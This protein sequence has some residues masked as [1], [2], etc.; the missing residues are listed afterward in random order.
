MTSVDLNIKARRMCVRVKDAKCRSAAR[1]FWSGRFG[2]VPSGP[3]MVTALLSQ[4]T[5]VQLSNSRF[6]LIDGDFTLVGLT[7]YW[8]QAF[9]TSV[10]IPAGIVTHLQAILRIGTFTTDRIV[11]V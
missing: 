8:T 2:S 9:F 5:N 3:G 4:R 11:C 6:E 1:M 7:K 10:S